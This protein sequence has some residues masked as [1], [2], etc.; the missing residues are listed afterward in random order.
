LEGRAG[1][2]PDTKAVEVLPGDRTPTVDTWFVVL[3][4]ELAGRLDG[5]DERTTL[6]ELG[7][8]EGCLNGAVPPCDPI[9]GAELIEELR[10]CPDAT[11]IGEKGGIDPVDKGEYGGAEGGAVDDWAALFRF[12]VRGLGIFGKFKGVGVLPRII[13]SKL[14]EVCS[15]I[16]I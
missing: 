2:L 5:V 7:A 1:A 8:S 3:P 16:M 10:E 9:P 12:A 6:K 15:R 13:A 14:A 4:S 11:D